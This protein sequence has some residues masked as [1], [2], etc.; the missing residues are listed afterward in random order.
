MLI[1][2]TAGI[3]MGLLGVGIPDIPVFTAML[4]RSIYEI[5][6]HYGFSYNS[7]E[8]KKF[9]LMLIRGALASK[10]EVESIDGQINA[11]I[12]K[13]V[14]TQPYDLKNQIIKASAC[15]S[16]ELLYMKFL[17]GI[18][19]VGAI[20]GAYD[21]VYMKQVTEYAE[22]KYRRRFYTQKWNKIRQS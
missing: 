12:E 10:E 3:G 20:G 11:Y 21:V 6:L 13:N 17:Q 22:L 18:P 8:E 15:L 9:I 2:G 14:W 7:E 4:L 1:S 19:I 5:A 16:G